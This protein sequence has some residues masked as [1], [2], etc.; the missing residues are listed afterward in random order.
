MQQNRLVTMTLTMFI[1]LGISW[2]GTSRTEEVKRTQA[3]AA[4]LDDIM[5]TPDKG[6]PEE[7]MESAQCVAIV[8]SML[9]GGFIVGARYGKGVATCRT[10][11]GW[12]A[13]VPLRVVGGSGGFQIGGEAVDL[14]MIIM[15]KGGMHD[16]L[17]S[18]F[19]LGADVSAAA[20]PV[21]RHAEGTTDWKMR[22]KVLTYSRSRGI[23][24]GVAL[25][26]A[27]ITQDWDSTRAFYGR[28]VPFDLIL[29][30]Q[31]PPPQGSREFL[32]AVKKYAAEANRA[33]ARP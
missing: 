9:N 2:A 16:L 20:G 28:K 10:E 30:D 25:D 24:A 6:I 27:P 33:E 19:K 18:K 3:A 31:V 29:T 22:A 21:G 5:A 23:F 1:L 7:I 15:N 26:G 11:S 32:E 14:V 12:S 4:V 8:P 13:P 17:S